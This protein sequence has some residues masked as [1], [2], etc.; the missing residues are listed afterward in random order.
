M[1]VKFGQRVSGMFDVVVI[2]DMVFYI[3]W[4]RFYFSN[5]RKF[6]AL[7]SKKPAL[8]Y[9]KLYAFAFKKMKPFK[10]VVTRNPSLA[11]EFRASAREQFKGVK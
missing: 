7:G 3:Y 9:K 8:A 4:P 10:V 5:L 11:D 2:G 1:H 6:H